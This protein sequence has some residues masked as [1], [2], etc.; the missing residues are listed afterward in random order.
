MRIFE[1]LHIIFLS[2]VGRGSTGSSGLLILQFAVSLLGIA[3][4]CYSLIKENKLIGMMAV[5]LPSAFAFAYIIITGLGFD[6]FLFN[7]QEPHII[8]LVARNMLTIDFVYEVLLLSAAFLISL[9]TYCKIKKPTWF[10]F[11]LSYSIE[12]ITILTFIMLYAGLYITD[13]PFNILLVFE[14]NI[15]M[16]KLF[17]YGVSSLILKTSATIVAILLSFLLKERK[18]IDSEKKY[19]SNK[20]YEEET[21]Y[22][23]KKDL[24]QI[25]IILYVCYFVEV[26]VFIWLFERNKG[27]IDLAALLFLLTLPFLLMALYANYKVIKMEKSKLFLTLKEEKSPGIFKKFHDEIILKNYHSQLLACNEYLLSSNTF[28]IHKRGLFLKS[29]TI[30]H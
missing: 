18:K 3:S 22:F 28:M 30:K 12:I 19:F 15:F 16:I 8:N 25:A 13:F 29:I 26:A 7:K 2:G 11:L 1:I 6:Y 27:T 23:L 9:F 17:L 10:E 5:V 24:K 21:L 20:F 4:H 14:K